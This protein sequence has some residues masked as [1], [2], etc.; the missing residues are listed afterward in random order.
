MGENA[1]ETR[2]RDQPWQQSTNIELMERRR[3]HVR[4]KKTAGNQF[5]SSVPTARQSNPTRRTHSPTET[6]LVPPAGVQAPY[7]PANL[8]DQNAR[9]FLRDYG[10]YV[11][12]VERHGASSNDRAVVTIVALVSIVKQYALRSWFFRGHT[13][14]DYFAFGC[15]RTD[16]GDLAGLWGI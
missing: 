6:T 11:T 4:T 2:T 16:S 14:T 13:C 10:E 15:S 12:Y 8:T 7:C 3:V 9:T 1:D 5:T